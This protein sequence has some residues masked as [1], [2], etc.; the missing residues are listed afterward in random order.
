LSLLAH[1]NLDAVPGPLGLVVNFPRYHLVHHSADVEEGLSNFGCHTVIFDRLFGTFR[2]VARQP[3]ALGVQPLGPRS[4]WQELI[5]PL[6][7]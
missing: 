2:P 1:A 6:F 3:V 7:R 5:A 4:V